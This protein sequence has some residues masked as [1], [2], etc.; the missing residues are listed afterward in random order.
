M[1]PYPLPD[2]RQ[3]PRTAVPSM[4]PEAGNVLLPNDDYDDIVGGWPVTAKQVAAFWA[5][6][7]VAVLALVVIVTFAPGYLFG[8]TTSQI[9]QT[10]LSWFIQTLITWGL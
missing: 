7:L 4:P 6:V 10:V 8:F 2:R 9:A 5:I 3:T 1:R